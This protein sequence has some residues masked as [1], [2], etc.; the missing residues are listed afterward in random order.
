M[1]KHPVVRKGNIR[2]LAALEVAE[3]LARGIGQSECRT[4]DQP[5][6]NN[7]PRRCSEGALNYCATMR[8]LIRS[9]RCVVGGRLEIGPTSRSIRVNDRFSAVAVNETN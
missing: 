3:I 9:T 7:A 4:G 6:N 2:D 8:P 1:G 5:A